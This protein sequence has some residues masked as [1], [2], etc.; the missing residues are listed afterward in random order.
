[1]SKSA[2]TFFGVSNFIGNLFDCACALDLT[3]H[4]IVM[5]CEETRRPRTKTIDERIALLERTPSVLPLDAFVPDDTE[6]YFLGT[7]ATARDKL[8]SELQE[9]FGIASANLIHPTA[10][11]SRFARVGNGVLVGLVRSSG[12]DAVLEDF[13][14]IKRLASVGHE[15]VVGRFARVQPGATVAGHVLLAPHVVIGLGANLIEELVIGERAF[16]GA[17][18]I[19]TGDV[20]PGVMVSGSPARVRRGDAAYGSDPSSRPAPATLLCS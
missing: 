17:S 2:I 19:V 3:P 8:A 20:P 7:G 6:S 18:S 9:R 13:A 1:M 5:N 16:V 10:Y 15:M 12:T 14:M 11:V 4:R